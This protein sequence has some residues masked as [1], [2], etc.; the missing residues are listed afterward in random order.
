MALIP[1]VLTPQQ[2]AAYRQQQTAARQSYGAGVAK[3]NFETGQRTA[4]YKQ[5]LG[6]LQQNLRQKRQGLNSTFNRRGVGALRS[7]LFKRGLNQD[8][9]SQLQQLAQ[10]QLGQQENL[11][12]AGIERQSLGAQQATTLAQINAARM[13]Q[14]AQLLQ[15]MKVPGA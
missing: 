3:S 14:L 7:G 10:L 15:S 11:G 5:N 12:N 9:Q 6:V 1:P 2:E 8:A 4:Q 13:A